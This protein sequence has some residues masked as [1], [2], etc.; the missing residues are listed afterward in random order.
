M[1]KSVFVVKELSSGAELVGPMRRGRG[2][3]DSKFLFS[4]KQQLINKNKSNLNKV[5][6]LVTSLLW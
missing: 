4:L 5:N 6:V 2:E 3:L 1:A